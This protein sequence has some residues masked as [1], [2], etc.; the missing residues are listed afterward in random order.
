KT[1]E[2]VIEYYRSHDYDFISITDHFMERFHYPV[3]DTTEFR[4]EAFTTLL[5]AELHGWGMENGELWH[6]VAN[7]LPAD[8]AGPDSNEDGQEIA[9]RAIKTGA[10]ITIGHPGW[11]GVTIQDALSLEDFDAIEIYNHG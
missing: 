3:T 2:E 8:F 9:A 7:G 5:G 11:N 6:I 1:P 10:F 4:D